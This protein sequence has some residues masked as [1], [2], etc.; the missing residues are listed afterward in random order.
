MVLIRSHMTVQVPALMPPMSER[1]HR[2]TFDPQFVDLLL[3]VVGR[4]L[5]HHRSGERQNP[6]HGNRNTLAKAIMEQ[7]EAGVTDAEELRQRALAAIPGGWA[8][9]RLRQ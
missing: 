8:P 9:V 2:G 5:R 7:A 6:E 1:F 4:G 3:R